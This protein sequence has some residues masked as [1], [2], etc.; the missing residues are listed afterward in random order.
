ML[1]SKRLATKVALA[2]SMAGTL[3]ACQAGYTASQTVDTVAAA[4]VITLGLSAA[5]AS[6]DF[7]TTSGAAIPQA[8][9][10]NVYEGL[11]R[12]DQDGEIQPLLATSWDISPDGRRYTFHL[13]QG[14]TFSNGDAFNA[15][16][17][18][19]S[20]E[21]VLS[22]A[23]TNGLKKGM[24]NVVA[25]EAVDTYTLQVDLAERSNS[26]LWRMGTLIG[27]M[28][29]PNGVDNLATTPVGTG[30]YEVDAWAV[31]TS[32]SLNA[33]EDYWGEA[34]ANQRAVLRYFGDQVALANAVRVG[35]IDAAIDVQAPELLDGLSQVDTLEVAVGTTNGEVI[36]SM[37]NTRAPFNDL[38]V[39]QAVMYGVDRQAIMATTWEGYGTDTGGAPVS[40][41]DPWFD[42]QVAQNAEYPFDPAR[43]RALME[44]AGAV[45]TPITI[46]V[47]S[48]TYATTASELLYSQLRDIGFEVQ[49]ETV[50]F[51]A[52]WIAKVLTQKDYDMS[53]VAHVEARDVGTLF[54]TPD[55]YLGFQDA[56]AQELLA[57][58]DSV[59]PEQYVPTMQQAVGRIVEQAGANTLYNL[60]NV[61]I[62]HKGVRG[63]PT[64]LVAD[65]MRLAEI[66]KREV[67]P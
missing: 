44:E 61:V 57:Q 46:S 62:V 3:T 16:T 33:R 5:P 36:L 52:V 23:W 43:A 67:N 20:I 38:R 9:M 2:A 42:P 22:D 6:L 37:N 21:R 34:P 53:I 41:T 54:G 35:D 45:G 40:P 25:V 4:D 65:G 11:V 28:M 39:R 26:W 56:T 10:G 32:L 50:E 15:D 59:A 51:P 55:Y 58:A 31:G 12:I 64:N 27:A 7:T 24:A 60:P 8:L 17:A 19:F 63:V 49:L 13:R 1:H 47:P 14:V 48:R 29:T 66:T 18:K 30:P